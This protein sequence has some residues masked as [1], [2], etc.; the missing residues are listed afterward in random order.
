LIL[1][2]IVASKREELKRVK[3]EVSLAE[4]EGQIARQR[5]PLDFA[6][7]LRA[8][9]VG[10][11]AEVK[12]ASPSKGILCPDFEPA[13]LAKA[14]VAGGAVAI[15]VLTEINYFQGSLDQ[16]ALLKDLPELREMPLLRKDFIF[17]PYQ[18]YESRAAGADAI[19]LI[20]A[21][22]NDEEMREL[23]GIVVGLGMQCLVEVHDCPEMERVLAS[24]SEIIGINN[25]D[26]TTFDVDI[27]TTER[28]RPLIPNDRIVVSESGISRDE[29]I[30]KLR[31]WGVNAALI[32]EALVTSSDVAARLKELVS[33]GRGE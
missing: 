23:Q 27:A 1:D 20:A 31:E 13:G 14:Y 7:A 3:A 24:G 19:L 18:V 15:S 21:V 26:L 8:D 6:A 33:V 22:L 16:L 11:I 32:G 10:I 4:L 25:R 17:D 5:R 9:G 2:D 12:K 29:N 28:L 30:K